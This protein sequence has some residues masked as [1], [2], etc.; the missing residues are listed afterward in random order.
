M[1][2]CGRSRADNAAGVRADG[3]VYG[4]ALRARRGPV[5]LAAATTAQE[6]IANPTPNAHGVGMQQQ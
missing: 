5:C 2:G 1:P 3:R 6:A 4:V